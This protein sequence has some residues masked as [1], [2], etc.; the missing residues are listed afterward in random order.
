MT[1]GQVCGSTIPGGQVSRS[2]I[3]RGQV[4]KLALA[5]SLA[6]VWLVHGL[7][8]KLLGGS[9]RHLA[10]VQ[11]V[12]G[13]GGAAG[14]LALTG[15]GLLEVGIAVW[16]LSR[17]AP[18][19]CAAVQTVMLLSMN[20]L[21]LTFARHLLLWPAGLVPLN[22]AFLAL[23]W[24]W[25]GSGTAD[26]RS[27][28]LTPRAAGSGDLTPGLARFGD[29]TPLRRHPVAVRATLRDCLTLTYAVPATVL[30][31]MLPPGLELDLVG[32]E[33]FV[34]VALV[35]T[36]RLRPDGVPA[37]LGGNFFL[38]GYRI[39]A[40]FAQADGRRLRGLR[41]L[42]SDT[43]RTL[44]ALGGNLLTHYNYHRC[45]AHMTVDTD[46]AR[47]TIDSND[48]FGDVDV[49]VRFDDA[50][51][52]ADS[53]FT[54]VREARHFAGPLPFTFEYEAATH[55][56][57]AVEGRRTHWRPAPVGVDVKR[58]TFFAQPAFA[59]C[60]PRLAA[61]FRVRDVEYHWLRGVR[62]AL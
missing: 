38:S 37:P 48:G 60:V 16:M 8:N 24:F 13:L 19:T 28:D 22:L 34:A 51:L 36:E 30:R 47:F 5:P 55:S 40:T 7:Y 52:P 59:G 10:I 39:F 62:H 35:Q 31:T 15:V 42:R 54:S 1:R 3:A 41:I 61:A 21:E 58:L 50:A 53:P 44:M 45:R 4:S 57:I 14:R 20:V 46:T 25:A 12:P 2:T 11:A 17:R 43:D 18:K 27:G 23:V 56:I 29:L 6:A 32:D 9:F 26:A 33:G 49:V